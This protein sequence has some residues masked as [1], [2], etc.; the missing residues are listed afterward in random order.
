MEVLGIKGIGGF[1]FLLVL[2]LSSVSA[3]GWFSYEDIEGTR[4]YY[5]AF[6]KLEGVEDSLLQISRLPSIYEE[7][8]NVYV[9]MS[10]NG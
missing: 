8:V 10:S 5:N 9:P 7:E 6:D 1:V 4:A 3:C 2:T